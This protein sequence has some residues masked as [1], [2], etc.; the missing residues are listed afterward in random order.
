[1]NVDAEN[2]V[3]RVYSGR[4]QE[5]EKEHDQRGVAIDENH[6]VETAGWLGLRP[7][8]PVGD[9]SGNKDFAVA[10]LPISAATADTSP[11]RRVLR[12][13]RSIAQ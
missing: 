11:A 2:K 10:E 6:S 9:R 7:F 4:A 5:P 3:V 13:S 1:V 12:A 8:A